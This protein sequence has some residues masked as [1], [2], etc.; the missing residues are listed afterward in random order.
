MFDTYFFQTVQK[1][2]TQVIIFIHDIY[3][4]GFQ[5]KPKPVDVIL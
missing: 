5:L 4:M 2:Y 3:V 1:E